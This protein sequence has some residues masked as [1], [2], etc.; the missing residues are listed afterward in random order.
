ML[1]KIEQTLHHLTGR[2]DSISLKSFTFLLQCLS[3][4]LSVFV[5]AQYIPHS[6][7]NTLPATGGDTGSHFWPVQVLHDFG[8]P[9]L[10]ARPWNPGNN[11]GEGLLVHYF[12]LPFLMMALLSYLI[13]VGLAFN[14]GTLFPVLFLPVSVWI[15]L[16]RM[17]PRPM[18]SALAALFSAVVIM[19]EGHSM[20]G[21]NSLSTLSGQFAHMYALNFFVLATGY[22]WSEIHHSHFPIKSAFLFSAVALSH[23]YIYFSVPFVLLTAA[24]FH[25]S[26]SLKNRFWVTSLSGIFS[27]LLSAWFLGPMVLNQS[28][29]TPHSFSWVFQ[30]WTQEA[31]PRI[32]DP[33]LFLVTISLLILFHHG[34]R[35]R[36]FSVLKLAIFWGC[37][38]FIYLGLF[39]FFRYLKLVDVRALPQTQLFWAISVA[40]FTSLALTHLPRKWNYLVA[41][42]GMVLFIPWTQWHVAKFPIWLDWNYS[43][44]ASK[45]NYPELIQLTERLKGNLSQPRVAYEH[46]LKNNSVGTER[47]FEMLPYF[48]NRATTESLYL[49]S[50]ILAPMIYSFTSEISENGS[51]PFTLWPCARFQLRNVEPHLKLLGIKS[52]ILSSQ[53]AVSEASATPFL[54]ERFSSGPW[55]LFDFTHPVPMA[56]TFS[57]E[58][59]MISSEDWKTRFWD[60]FNGYGNDKPFLVVEKTLPSDRTQLKWIPATTCHPETR[61]DFSG[62]HLK[63]D[64]PGVA[65]YLKYAYNPSFTASGGETIFLV[66][67]GYLGIVPASHEV[68]LKFGTSSSW[69]FFKLIS[70]ATLILIASLKLFNRSNGILPLKP[71]AKKPNKPIKHK[72]SSFETLNTRPLFWGLLSLTFAIYL[73]ISF[74]TDSLF[75]WRWRQL[76]F[77][78]FEIES[79]Q[80]DWGALQK[81]HDLNGNPIVVKGVIYHSGL[82]THANSEIRL[83][84]KSS[85]AFFKGKCGYPDHVFGAEIQCEVVA[86]S[87]VLF[88]SSPLN[89]SSREQSFQVPLNGAKEI[90]LIYR[91]LKPDITAAH[92]VWVGLEI[93]DPP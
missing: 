26:Q 88:Q 68:D 51:C 60:W 74:R 61:A 37:L 35:K 36:D 33:F 13:P 2:L 47:V 16:R 54:K 71:V 77:G 52:L 67:P 23:G 6:W 89:N 17:S 11:G 41:A 70:L 76:N 91:T 53:L 69:I 10:T 48:A 72:K 9:H 81:N 87:Q 50:T 40:C 14:L 59:V 28:W 30:D 58:P 65:H 27:G 49:Q 38:G 3:L 20:W 32:F 83:K 55:K 7:F 73:F 92:G 18:V 34:F 85:K 43:G 24:L 56:D 22:L 5:I 79:S 57:K 39:F 1:E 29:V 62:I 90:R 42:S 82:A 64:C 8:I 78:D 45:T 31:M 66:S 21:G 75:F 4:F 12:P 44:W 46:H 80:Q 25:P 93:L 84:N 63:T 15:A 19:N 86:G